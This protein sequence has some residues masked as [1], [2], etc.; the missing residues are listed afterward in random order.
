VGDSLSWLSLFY[1]GKHPE[2]PITDWWNGYSQNYEPAGAVD[3]FEDRPSEF[4]WDAQ[5]ADR[6]NSSP[7]AISIYRR[8]L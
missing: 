8:R 3:V 7:P 1:P 5:L 6:T 2:Q 4:F